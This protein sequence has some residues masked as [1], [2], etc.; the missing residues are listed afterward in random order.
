MANLKIIKEPSGLKWSITVADGPIQWLVKPAVKFYKRTILRDPFLVSVKQWKRDRGDERLR[1]NY[2]LTADSVVL[3]VGG[4]VGDFASAVFEKFGSRVLIFEPMQR[5]YEQCEQRFAHNNAVTV[6][7]YGLGA[8]DEQ[9]QLSDSADASSFCRDGSGGGG[10]TAQLR[11]VDAVWRE[12]K[13][14]QIDLMKINIE[15][16]E[17]SLLRRMLDLGLA[18]RVNNFQVQ[19]HN[20]VPDAVSL[21][22]ELRQRLAATH[23]EDWCYDFV[24]EN[25]QN[26]KSAA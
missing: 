26:R 12:L 20:F 2:P 5:F 14:E 17:Y 6:F 13:L 23:T 3:D 21:R 24:W 25:W 4:Y 8:A 16:G 11:D 15:G 18:D 10:V 1:M 19:F 22:E 9:L 7:N